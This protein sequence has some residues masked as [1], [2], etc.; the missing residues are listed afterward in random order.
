MTETS[1]LELECSTMRYDMMLPLREGRVPIDGVKI[2][3]T[4]LGSMVFN[5]NTPLKEGNFGLCDLNLGFF[6]PAMEAGWELI[7]LP[8]FS[9]R[10]PVFT[11]AFC[12]ADAG[13]ESP[14]DLEGKRIGSGRYSSAITVWLRGFLRHRYGVDLSRVR[15]VVSAPDFFAARAPA[16]QIEMAADRDK[17]PIDWLLDG[18][19]DAIMTDISDTKLFDTL[20]NS[21]KVK[22]LFPDYMDEDE[23]LYRD[24]GIFTPVH[25]M[26]MSK[27]LDRQYPDLAGKLYRAFEQSKQTATND[28]LSDMRG[29]GIVY[30]RE[31]KKE[32]M[33]RWGDPWKHG[34]TGN[35]S[36]IDTFIDYNY[37]EG[38]ISSKPP[39]DQIFAAGTLDT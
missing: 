32:E 7:G 2:R 18:E 25:M 27:K 16:C 19:V 10:K 12:R 33:E 39:Y 4:Q 17:S 35:Q 5:E 13:I 37:R 6:L 21:P 8:V 3:P 11:Y 22:R 31:Q 24:T 15:W 14:R 36:T 26:V 23:R 28:I 30:L 20:E 34:I 1:E 29:F 9:K 38:M